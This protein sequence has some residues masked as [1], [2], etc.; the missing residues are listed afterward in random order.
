MLDC[1]GDVSLTSDEFLAAAKQCMAVEAEA[2]KGQVPRDVAQAL[3]SISQ[4]VMRRRV[5]RADDKG[6]GE[7]G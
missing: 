4:F 2:Q 7:R 5:S 6:A 1:G 3:K